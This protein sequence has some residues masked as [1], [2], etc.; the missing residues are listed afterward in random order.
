MLANAKLDAVLL[1]SPTHLHAPMALAAFRRGLHVL[2]EKPMAADYREAQAIARAAKRANRVLTVYQPHRLRDYFQTVL[3]V[4]RSGR[5]GKVFHVKRAH[6]AFSRRDDWQALRK[7]GGGMLRNSGAHGADQLL[8]ITGSNIKRVFCQLRRVASLGDAEDVVKMVYETREGVL[9]E[10]EINHAS[11]L[12][13]PFSWRYTA[14]TAASVSRMTA[15]DARS[16]GTTR[17]DCRK[18]SWTEA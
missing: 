7:Y 6:Y 13:P 9:G 11:L 16:V 2:L 1:A 10:L 12:S 14:R 4:L 18:A 15:R 5:L 3:K 8:A 17:S